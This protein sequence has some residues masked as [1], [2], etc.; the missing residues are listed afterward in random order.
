V[1]NYVLALAHLPEPPEGYVPAADPAL[2]GSGLPPAPK[3]P[4]APMPV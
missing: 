2:E 1:Q 4:A 3:P